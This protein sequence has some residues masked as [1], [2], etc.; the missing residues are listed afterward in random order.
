MTTI[1]TGLRDSPRLQP[2]SVQA[3]V[4]TA[5]ESIYAPIKTDLARVERIMRDALASESDFIAELVKRVQLYGGKRMR[6][7]MLLL[8][9]KACGVVA[10]DHERL[11]ACIELIHVATLVH[12]DVL[13]DADKRRHVA[14]VNA[15]WGADASLLLGDFLFTHAFQLAA[16]TNTLDACRMLGRS[17]NTLCAGELHQV[18]RRGRFD[19]SEAEYL[20]VLSGKTAELF[21]CACALGARYAGAPAAWEAA[22]AAYGRNVGV[23]FQIADDV[24]DLLGEEAVVGKPVGSD[25]RKQKMTLPLIRLRETGDRRTVERLRE[26]FENPER[27]SW[28]AIGTMLRE[29]DALQYTHRRGQ[30]F[31]EAAAAALSELPDTPARESLLLLKDFALARTA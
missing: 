9:A 7:A 6:P 23:A 11:A 22:L 21:A 20:E 2:A 12:D 10:P 16:S 15:E 3:D 5:L 4:R 18:S 27:N 19:L 13:D 26:R 31:L 24:I 14:T 17:T 29:S 28:E 1:A 30:E 25:F 8:A